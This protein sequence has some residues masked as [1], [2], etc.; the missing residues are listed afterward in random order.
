MTEMQDKETFLDLIASSCR[1]QSLVATAMRQEDY[2]K[3]EEIAG[4]MSE[5]VINLTES[6]F[7]D[8]KRSVS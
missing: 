8:L 1:I 6:Q 7:V 4:L 3:E 2:C 5:Y